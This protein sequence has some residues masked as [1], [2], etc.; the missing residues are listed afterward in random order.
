MD[1]SHHPLTEFHSPLLLEICTPSLSSALTAFHSGAHRI[2]LCTDLTSGGLTPSYGL[3]RAVKAKVSIPVHVLIRPRTGGFVYNDAEME[4]MKGDIDVAGQLGCEGVVVGC[5]NDEERVDV[6]RTGE[7]VEVAKRW[8][9]GV[10]F[11]RAFDDTGGGEEELERVVSAGCERVLTSGGCESVG[12]D[13]A[14]E[15]LKKLVEVARGRVVVMPGGGV[16]VDNAVRVL[17]GCG[18]R[19]IHASCKRVVTVEGQQRGRFAVERWETD[20]HVVKA[21]LSRLNHDLG[22]CTA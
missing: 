7:L 14:V 5:L 2:E 19:E 9:M 22:R 15:R 10:T 8:G 1:T 11:H 12:E 21:L 16:T 18:A 17:R 20:E 13:V 3:I 4:V 6:E